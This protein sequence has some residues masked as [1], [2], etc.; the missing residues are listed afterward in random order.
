MV[1]R[2]PSA[3]SGKWLE[4]ATLDG[5]LTRIPATSSALEPR[6]DAGCFVKGFGHHQVIEL[7]NCLVLELLA[8][9]LF[10]SFRWVNHWVS[11]LEEIQWEY[12]SAAAGC[13]IPRLSSQV[14]LALQLRH[15][16]PTL[17]GRD[18]SL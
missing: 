8:T 2:R 9:D 16:D 5:K 13:W 17:R 18:P 11:F 10:I 1:I 6:H 3:R 4:F 14:E 12:S 7:L 15:F